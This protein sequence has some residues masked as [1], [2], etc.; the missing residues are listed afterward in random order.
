MISTSGD[1]FARREHRLVRLIEQRLQGDDSG[2]VGNARVRGLPEM[3][4][5]H[6]LLQVVAFL[7][8]KGADAA[9]NG[10]PGKRGSGDC[11][12]QL[13]DL[14][15]N[16]LQEDLEAVPRSEKGG[17]CKLA[18]AD[19]AHLG[20]DS[21]TEYLYLNESAIQVA[22]WIQRLAAARAD[23]DEARQVCGGDG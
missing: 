21:P 22:V 10:S 14:L 17:V 1:G 4:R 19:L 23:L 2:L 8:S 5:R 9:E 18:P 6:G 15:Q 16:A 11:D 13:L 20:E 7:R 12:Q 3:V